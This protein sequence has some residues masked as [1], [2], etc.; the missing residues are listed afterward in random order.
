M[1]IDSYIVLVII[2]IGIASGVAAIFFLIKGLKENKIIHTA[3]A[4]NVLIVASTISA[5]CYIMIL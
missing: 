4:G 2:A 3:L 1:T 5:L